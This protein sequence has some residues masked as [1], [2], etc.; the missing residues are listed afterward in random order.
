VVTHEV[1]QS[2]SWNSVTSRN[3]P[4]ATLASSSCASYAGPYTVLDGGLIA[5]HVHVSLLPNWI[6]GTQYRAAQ[7]DDAHLELAPAEPILLGGGLRS[8]R[9]VWRRAH[10]AE[11]GGEDVVGSG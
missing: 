10:P 1:A 8:A 11:A 3:R 7:L 4:V 6:G 2:V 9:L 5:H